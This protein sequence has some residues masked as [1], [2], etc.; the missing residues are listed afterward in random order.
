MNYEVKITQSGRGGTIYFLETGK[1]LPFGW[2]LAIDGALLF[3]SSLP[4]WENFFG[5]IDLPQAQNRRDEI[6]E[7]VCEEV[8][9]QQTSGGKYA[10][11]DDYI[12]ISFR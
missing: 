11:E 5:A 12:S 10:I 8:V 7:R 3:F 4:D 6:V 1:E 9:R 2:E